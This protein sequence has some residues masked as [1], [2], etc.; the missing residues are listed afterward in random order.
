MED[1]NDSEKPI[2]R[3]ESLSQVEWQEKYQYEYSFSLGEKYIRDNHPDKD[4]AE[5]AR[6]GGGYIR[7]R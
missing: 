7:I 4:V 3:V 1:K 5:A 6:L 2:T